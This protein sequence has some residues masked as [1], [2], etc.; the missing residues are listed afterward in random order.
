MG[1]IGLAVEFRAM[2]MG[3]LQSFESHWVGLE[4]AEKEG[5]D[6]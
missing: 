4:A 1:E 6:K 5:K 2:S 3:A